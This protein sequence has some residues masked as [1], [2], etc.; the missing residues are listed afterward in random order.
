MLCH[1]NNAVDNDVSFGIKEPWNTTFIIGT[2][3]YLFHAY[4]SKKFFVLF[5]FNL[6]HGLRSSKI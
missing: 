5:I 2:K 3:L 6:L 1:I 4:T